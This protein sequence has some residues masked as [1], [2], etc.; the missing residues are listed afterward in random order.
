[1]ELSD[2][3][4]FDS[5]FDSDFDS[6]FDSVF[7]SLLDPDSDLASPPVFFSADAE[8]VAELLPSEELPLDA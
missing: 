4:G 6:D 8:S 1:M 5:V 3:A 2:A 7:D